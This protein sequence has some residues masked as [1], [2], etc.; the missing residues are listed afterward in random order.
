LVIVDSEGRV[1]LPRELVEKLDSKY[2][3]VEL[4]GKR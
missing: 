1:K 2:L 4:R 3:I